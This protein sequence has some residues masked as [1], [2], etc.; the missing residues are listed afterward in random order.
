[1]FAIQVLIKN[2]NAYFEYFKRNIQFLRKISF[3]N[4]GTNTSQLNKIFDSILKTLGENAVPSKAEQNEN[5]NKSVE[6]VAVE[7][8]SINAPKTVSMSKKISMQI[9]NQP[10]DATVKDDFT[11]NARS[12]NAVNKVKLDPFAI[13]STNIKSDQTVTNVN[14]SQS[15][16]QNASIQN[17][18][19]SSENSASANI[20]SIPVEQSNSI[21][22][23]LLDID[24]TNGAASSPNNLYQMY[25]NTSPVMYHN[26]SPS[27]F[28]VSYNNGYNTVPCDNYPVNNYQGFTG[29]CQQLMYSPA[30]NMYPNYQVQNGH[31]F[32]Q[33]IHLQQAN[34]HQIQQ[35]DQKW[36]IDWIIPEEECHLEEIQ[37]RKQR[38]E[39]E[40]RFEALNFWIRPNFLF[41]KLC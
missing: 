9:N 15:N 33:S 40:L 25:Q 37:R 26:M 39:N 31:K 11:V 27:S 18:V 10:N 34:P 30:N 38:E 21:V 23:S 14:G 3:E 17:L 7:K 36:D 22:N 41:E 12:T 16:S 32:G 6:P 35:T 19:C 20:A 28:S 1:M 24:F 2:I 29:Q 4:E 8:P 13:R 5:L